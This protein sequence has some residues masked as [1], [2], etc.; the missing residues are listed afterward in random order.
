MFAILDRTL[1]R[2]EGT[3]ADTME[4]D[5]MWFVCHLEIISKNI[6][7]DLI[8]AKNLMVKCFSP[9]YEVFRN[10][11]N[12]YHK[13]LSTQIQELELE[14]LEANEIMSLFLWVLNIYPSTEMVGNVELGLEVDMNVLEILL[15]PN[16]VSEWL[17]MCMSTLTSN[18][19]WLWKA[20]ETD[21]KDQVEEPEPGADQSEYHHS[22]LIILQ[23]FEQILQVAAQICED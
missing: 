23:M 9:Y 17:H 20:L 6:L 13:A 15:S 16:I 3:Q 18:I 11:L 2:I 21:R 12:M 10:H 5:K 22:T 4:S 14:D 19:A 1:T 7:D 8:F